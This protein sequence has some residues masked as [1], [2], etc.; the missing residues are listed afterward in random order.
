MMNGAVT[1]P[2]HGVLIFAPVGRDA[3][4]TREVLRRASISC[5][6]CASISML[7]E[8]LN[9]DGGGALLMTEEALDEPGFAELVT[10]LEQQP[11][12]SDIP[13]L[14]F[15]GGPGAE[16]TTRAIRSIDTL[17]NVTLLERP[18]R[19]AAV[20]TAVRAALRG[21]GRQ[22]EV[23]DLLVALHRARSQ[24]ESANRLKDE[25]LATLS[26]EL[27]TPSMR[28]SDGRRC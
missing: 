16:M 15:A 27:R 10:I 28:S 23:R 25:F 26:H 19:L 22:Y 8:R 3:E 9:T 1:D 2:E 7:N 14:L 11:P 24:A 21:R 5:I 18:I 12:W 4:L 17:R 20:L 13:V 6:V